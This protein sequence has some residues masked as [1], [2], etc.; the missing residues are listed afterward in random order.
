MT[1]LISRD[2]YFLIIALVR[3]KQLHC[4]DAE[5][6]SKYFNLKYCFVLTMECTVFFSTI[7]CC[8]P[9]LKSSKNFNRRLKLSLKRHKLT[10]ILSVQMFCSIKE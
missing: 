4:T 3:L 2:Y 9:T 5:H 7:F 8:V 10:D 1:F 6:I